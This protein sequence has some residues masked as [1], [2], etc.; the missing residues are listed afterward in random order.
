MDVV[1]FAACVPVLKSRAR[2]SAAIYLVQMSNEKLVKLVKVR[3]TH[4]NSVWFKMVLRGFCHLQSF[5]E[6]A[7]GH[8]C[9]NK[10]SNLKMQE[11]A[12]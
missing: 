10:L 3:T 5:R 12:K 8:D 2:Q 11:G 6:S 9:F 1:V 4:F 7:F